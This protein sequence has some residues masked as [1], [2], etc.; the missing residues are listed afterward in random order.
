MKE[1]LHKIKLTD[2]ES[3]GGNKISSLTEIADPT[4]A[5]Q[6][7]IPSHFF[8]TKSLGTFGEKLVWHIFK[9]NLQLYTN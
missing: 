3:G 9:L 6:Y 8:K 7:H 1:F 5:H 4:C 2:F